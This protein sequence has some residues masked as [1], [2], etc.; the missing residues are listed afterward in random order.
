MISN[1][2]NFIINPNEKLWS[3]NTN[4]HYVKLISNHIKL[5]VNPMWSLMKRLP[6][7]SGCTANED[8]LLETVAFWIDWWL[9]TKYHN[10]WASK[11]YI[12]AMGNII[13][14]EKKIT[15]F[16]NYWTTVVFK[17]LFFWVFIDSYNSTSILHHFAKFKISR[18]FLSDCASG[19]IGN[20]NVTDMC[21]NA[22]YNYL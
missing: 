5:I 11:L 2:I 4:W 19:N 3:F 18:Q 15:N 17:E 22:K 8:N 7:K 9:F 14:I 10:Q 21:N 16:H 6:M 13:S 12:K 1:Q 20:T